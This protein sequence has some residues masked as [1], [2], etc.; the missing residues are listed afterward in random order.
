MVKNKGSDY[1]FQSSQTLMSQIK[2]NVAYAKLGD[3]EIQ[4]VLIL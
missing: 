1:N 3:F 4:H 2:K